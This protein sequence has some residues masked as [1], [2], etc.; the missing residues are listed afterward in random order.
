[1]APLLRS[2]LSV[3]NVQKQLII[4]II[5]IIIIITIIIISVITFNDY[6]IITIF[7]M[8]ILR[9]NGNMKQMASIYIFS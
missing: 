1:M 9:R 8:Q 4:I 2:P 7:L 6:S 5:I 3:S